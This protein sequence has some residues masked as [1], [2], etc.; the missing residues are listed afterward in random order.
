MTV[1]DN[2]SSTA[3]LPVVVALPLRPKL[4]RV[5]DA[6]PPM[7]RP[8]AWRLGISRALGAVVVTVHGAL[9]ARTSAMLGDALRELIDGQ[10]NLFVVVDVH[11]MLVTEPAAL[12]VLAA[13]RRSLE[14]RDGRFLV[15]APS[16]ETARALRVRGLGA[17]IELHPERRHHPSA[18]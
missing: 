7:P 13:A 18:Q 4:T 12:R 14:E 11:D 2:A 8:V 16:Q 17:V 15:A 6:E 1:L 9:N 5:A 10:G 3:S